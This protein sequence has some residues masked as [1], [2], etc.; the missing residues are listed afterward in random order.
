M[1][2]YGQYSCATADGHLPSGVSSRDYVIRYTALSPAWTINTGLTPYTL[3]SRPRRILWR[4][5]KRVRVA[6]TRISPECC[7]GHQARVTRFLTVMHRVGT[8]NCRVLRSS[9]QNS[10][11][12]SRQ[13]TLPY[14]CRVVGLLFFHVARTDSQ[15]AKT[16]LSDNFLVPR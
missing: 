5:L 9:T 1:S 16:R 2:N 11:A 4:T 12:R 8:K 15:P 7:T 6:E 10:R 14:R 13:S 3:C